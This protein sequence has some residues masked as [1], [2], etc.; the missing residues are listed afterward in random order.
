MSEEDLVVGWTIGVIHTSVYPKKIDGEIN[1][2]SL[3]VMF[4]KK[5]INSI[6]FVL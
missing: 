2:C 3:I 1:K 6:F 5:V 4:K